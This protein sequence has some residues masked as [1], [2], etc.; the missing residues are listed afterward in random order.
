MSD[1]PVIELSSY[2]IFI[3]F[4]FFVG[5]YLSFPSDF[6]IC[7]LIFS[8]LLFVF[9]PFFCCFFF[10]KLFSFSFQ[11]FIFSFSP[12]SLSIPS[13]F[14]ICSLIFYVL[15]LVF[16]PFLFCFFFFCNLSS[17]FFIHFVIFSFPSYFSQVSLMP[18]LLF[19][20]YSLFCLLPSFHFCVVSSSFPT[21]LY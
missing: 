12:V 16:I 21:F 20:F 17:L 13:A 6:V 11:S 1:F 9:I 19:G 4:I 3:I 2:C 18:L 10:C 8:L 15:P 7:S 14:V 5:I